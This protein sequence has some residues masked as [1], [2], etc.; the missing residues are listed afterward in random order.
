MHPVDFRPCVLEVRVTTG[1]LS[2]LTDRAAR[3]LIVDGRTAV[4][5]RSSVSR[6]PRPRPSADTG[7][8]LASTCAQ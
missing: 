5:E 4:Y 8:R 3:Q 2:R 6:P 1:V 7:Q